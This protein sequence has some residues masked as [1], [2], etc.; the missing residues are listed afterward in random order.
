MTKNPNEPSGVATPMSIPLIRRTAPPPA[1]DHPGLAG[2][3]KR[4]DQRDWRRGSAPTNCPVSDGHSGDSAIALIAASR[5][6][7]RA[8][9]WFIQLAAAVSGSTCTV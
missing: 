3:R 8:A 7:Q 2:D 4:H 1:R 9:T 5:A 6:S